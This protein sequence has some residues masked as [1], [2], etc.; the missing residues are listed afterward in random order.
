[1]TESIAAALAIQI[2]IKYWNQPKT[3][4]MFSTKIDK[5]KHFFKIIYN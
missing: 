1:M 4:A 3:K 5:K 2:N